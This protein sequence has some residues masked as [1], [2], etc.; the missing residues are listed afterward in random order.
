MFTGG[1]LSF[2]SLPQVH[3]SLDGELSAF[4]DRGIEKRGSLPHFMGKELINKRFAVREEESPG[5]NG[6]GS[7]L[8]S[9]VCSSW[10][11]GQILL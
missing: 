11:C 6:L 4:H 8:S 5:M 3:W 10:G 9:T 7:T 2:P 1:W